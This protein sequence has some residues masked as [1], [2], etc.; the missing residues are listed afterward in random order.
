MRKPKVEYRVTEVKFVGTPEEAEQTRIVVR[1][2]LG[3]YY[4]RVALQELRREMENNS[5][6]KQVASL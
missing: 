4:T 5:G 6:Q 3:R 2:L 1:Q